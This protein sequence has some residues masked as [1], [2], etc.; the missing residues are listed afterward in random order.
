VNGRVD[1][2]G[3][4][5]LHVRLKN[6]VAAS[7]DTADIWIDTAFTGYLVLPLDLIRALDL[8]RGP[9]VPA[10]LADGSALDVATYVCL[11]LWFG[12]WKDIEVIGNDGRFP[13]L[14][15]GLLRDRKLHVDYKRRTLKLN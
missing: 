6:P 2:A 8:P 12:E 9:I 10:I 11:V 13:L 4:A 15:I 3:R 14:G 5:L 7:E 1:P